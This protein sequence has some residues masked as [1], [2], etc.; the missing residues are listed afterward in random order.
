MSVLVFDENAYARLASPGDREMFLFKWL[1]NLDAHLEEEEEAATTHEE[2]KLTQE[3]LEQ[4]LLE[5]ATIPAPTTGGGERTSSW[6]GGGGGGSAVGQAKTVL[7]NVPKPSRVVRD[8]TAKC[9]ARVFEV[10]QV[11]RIGAT[12]YAVQSTLGA[13]RRSVEREARLSA[14]AVAGVLFEALATKAGFRL[15][16]CFSDFLALALKLARSSD[17]SIAVRVEASRTVCKLLQG[18]GKTAGDGSVREAAKA[19]RANLTHRSPLLVLASIQALEAL[20]V[21]TPSLQSTDKGFEAETLVTGTLVPMLATGVLVVRRAIARLV[22][23]VIAHSIA[24]SPL[25]QMAAV[26]H[27]PAVRAD[28][29]ARAIARTR[30][31]SIQRPASA[32]ECL[33]TGV[34]AE[35]IGSRSSSELKSNFSSPPPPPP[36]PLTSVGEGLSTALVWLSQ[37][38]TRASASR[39]LRSGIIDAYA[40]LFDELGAEAAETQYP[41]I[42]GHVLGVLAASTQI[43][44]A[45][46]ADSRNRVQR[47]SGDSSAVGL[48]G[49]MDGRAEADILAL[50]NMCSWLL[51]VPLAQALLSDNG[52]HVAAQWIWDHW[53]AGALPPEVLSVVAAAGRETAWR[54]AAPVLQLSGEVALLVALQEWRMLVSDLGEA[55]RAL[56]VFDADDRG[57]LW[58]VPLERWLADSNEAV[59]ISAAAALSALVRNDPGRLSRVLSTLI[60]RLQQFCA[61]CSSPSHQS[62]ATA[63]GSMKRTTGY[64]YAIA[65]VISTRDLQLYVPL[66]LAEWVHSIAIRLLNAAYHRAE[67]EIVGSGKLDGA[68]DP[69]GVVSSLLPAGAPR[70]RGSSSSSSRAL[71]EGPVALANTRM[72]AGWILLAG[73]TTGLGSA[74]V[75][76]RA[77]DQWMGLWMAALPVPSAN[78]AGFVTGDMPW[79]LRAHWLQSRG[80]ALAHLACF[81]R[82]C[83]AEELFS[84]RLGSDDLRRVVGSLKAAL[85]F[86]DNALDAPLPP[87]STGVDPARPVWQLPNQTSLLVS[88]MHV[89][90]R[91]AECLQALGGGEADLLAPMTLPT[92][93]LMELA[94]GSIDNLYEMLGARIGATRDAPCAMSPALPVS[95]VGVD[96]ESGGPLLAGAAPLRGFRSGPWGYEAETGTTTLLHDIS[97]GLE[98]AVSSLAA[99]DFGSCAMR[100]AEH[101]WVS[102]LCPMPAAFELAQPIAVAG[103]GLLASHGRPSPPAYTCLVDCCVQ[104]FGRLFPSFSPNAQ[105]TVLDG[106]ALQ[107][108][109]L[110]LNSHRH[111][112]VLT[113]VLAAVYGAIRAISGSR[114]EVA[115][116][117]ARGMADVARMA[118]ALPSAP[119]RLV[120]GEVI[121]SLA[122]VTRDAAS[123]YL[124]ALMEHLTGQAIR[125]RDRFARAGAAVALGSLYA[126]AGSIVA[127][128]ALRQVVVL[129]HSLASD[130]DPVVHAWALG[131]LGEAAMSA[132]FMFEPFARDSFHMALKLLL[133]DSH[134][135]PLHASALWVRGRDHVPSAQP[136]DCAG[137]HGRVLP[138]RAGAGAGAGAAVGAGA[139]PG[140]ACGRDAALA[141][142][143]SATHHGRAPDEPRLAAA[144]DADYAF[145]CARADA[146]AFDARAALGHLVSSLL[147]VFGPSL[148][149]DAATRDSVLTLLRELRRA[150]PPPSRDRA[151]VADPDARWQTAAQFISAT[152]KQLLFF[153]PGDARFLPLFVARTLRPIMRTRRVAYYGHASGIHA[154]HRVAVQALEGVLRLY[155]ARIVQNANAEWALCDVVWEALVLYGSAQQQGS[156]CAGLLGDLRRLVHTVA[157]LACTLEQGLLA[158]GDRPAPETMAVLAALCAVF[159]KRATEGIPPAARRHPPGEAAAA[160]GDDDAAARPFSAAAKQLAISAVVSILECVDRLRPSSSS[161]SSSSSTKAKAKAHPLTPLLAD[162]VSVGYMAASSPPTQSPTLCCLGQHLLQRLIGQFGNVEDPALRGEGHHHH[163]HHHH[164]H[165]HSVL[166]IYQAQLSSAFMPVLLLG[167]TPVPEIMQAAVA[168]AT[169]FVVSGLVSSDRATL[170]R[171]LRLL[172]PQPAFFAPRGGGD[173]AGLLAVTPQMHI[174]TR[175]AVLRAWAVIHRYAATT[176]RCAGVLADALDLHLPL[177]AGLWIDAIRDSAVIGLRPRNVYDELARLGCRDSADLLGLC[178]GLE[179]S[180]VS[181]VREPLAVWYRACL[182]HF[183]ASVSC[184]L[185]SSSSSSSGYNELKTRLRDPQTA[186]MLLGFALQELTR[187]SVLSSVTRYAQTG[188]LGV[189]A[190]EDN[191]F[192]ADAMLVDPLDVVCAGDTESERIASLQRAGICVYGPTQPPESCPIAAQ[193]LAD[194]DLALSL[195]STLRAIH[196]ET[197]SGLAD[198]LSAGSSSSS[199]WLVKEL[200]TLAVT[201]FVASLTSTGTVDAQQQRANRALRVAAAEKALDVASVLLNVVDSSGLLLLDRW[202]FS[203]EDPENRNVTKDNVP[204]L[205]GLGAFGRTVVRDIVGTWQA[206][207][208]LEEASVVKACLEIMAMI[209]SRRLCSGYAAPLV[210]FWLGLWR[211]SMLKPDVAACSLAG[212]VRCANE[213]YSTA[214]VGDMC[215]ALLLQLLQTDPL[216][217]LGVVAHLLSGTPET[218]GLQMSEAV[219]TRFATVF[220]AKLTDSASHTQES[221][222]NLHTLLQTLVDLAQSKAPLRV[223]P[224]LARATIPVLS[225]LLNNNADHLLELILSALSAFATAQYADPT[226]SGLV[227]AVVLMLLLSLLPDDALNHGMLGPRETCLAEAILGL[228]TRAPDT[229]RAVLFRLAASQPTAKRRLE[230]AIRSRSSAVTTTEPAASFSSAS[231]AAIAEPSAT[232]ERRIALKSSFG[233]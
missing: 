126:R 125:A 55:S 47:T 137:S 180:Y 46:A 79:T 82:T 59:R 66:D 202:L 38:F 158:L 69:S 212:F 84:Y 37:A 102:I 165:R 89:R 215:N 187:L 23:V 25:Q 200:W 225:S 211:Q 78:G 20:V 160:L 169:A 87:N 184:L 1:S 94:M 24:T 88:H 229:F 195:L 219:Q 151:P 194:M 190:K 81:L 133:S 92:V 129:L 227:M 50:R 67:P 49:A 196:Q 107:L 171:I 210:A 161:S 113:N 18:G 231:D 207:H 68:D 16:S 182:P 5:V 224:T 14:L 115:P 214:D 134:A 148:Q 118:L 71:G 185:A 179:S 42:A 62:V 153:A 226:H 11:H 105:Q 201:N 146:D 76:G 164:H 183:L 116:H 21:C 130:K 43:P 189:P 112:A 8:L 143:N 136:A 58:V 75:G 170:T 128:G 193:W 232:A 86:V 176:S 159:T 4:I 203:S 63:V 121:G 132:G 191:P 60:S 192:V 138:P 77:R 10:G 56:D 26:T 114:G 166:A 108:R 177:L 51:R 208:K 36:S 34:S 172:A 57:E 230:L 145:V 120:G 181:V 80:M 122:A 9:L 124:P 32:S 27:E 117:V 178:L 65:G 206:A 197:P 188:L 39:E 96:P 33:S 2:L 48:V 140:A 44:A 186:T 72:A 205:L 162:L 216:P 31:D 168:T 127:S 154:F 150:L 53:L 93:R 100:A 29:A 45:E 144:P 30:H 61:H 95:S 73:L 213:D 152:Q 54:N 218:Q 6:L 91:V 209:V 142:P 223:L 74:F 174:V 90:Q 175:L 217:A 131:A 64:A 83:Q 97:A 41:V 135:L 106:L 7:S 28:P 157:S 156:C 109:A 22:A 101:D 99:G 199:S 40:A 220:V 104:L 15:L 17:E 228:A 110:P 204:A 35:A 3:R 155:G 19:L 123:A 98:S 149:A 111:M 163:H 119:H 52:K 139:W 85:V 222:Q 103:Q 167:E 70:R 13:K 233:I 141:H 12:L 173:S 147:L 221:C 198:L